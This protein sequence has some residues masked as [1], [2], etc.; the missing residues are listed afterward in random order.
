MHSRISRRQGASGTTGANGVQLSWAFRRTESLNVLMLTRQR[1]L[2]FLQR[3][4]T[5]SKVSHIKLTKSDV[6]R[7]TAAQSALWRAPGERGEGVTF[8]VIDSGVDGK[9]RPQER[10]GGLNCVGDEVRANPPRLRTGDRK[11]G[12][13]TRHTCCGHRRRARNRQRFSRCS[14]GVRNSA[15]I[16]YF[17][18]IHVRRLTTEQAISTSP[19]QSTPPSR[20]N[21]ISSI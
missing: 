15:S 8:G 7:L 21:A 5:A 14:A 17:R 19:R 11:E 13:R 16:A 3:K 12:R 10:S 4:H 9:H 2:G 6:R 20:T 1:L 18:I